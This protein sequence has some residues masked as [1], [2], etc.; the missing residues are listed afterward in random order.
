MPILDNSGK[1]VN[2]VFGKIILM[3]DI[4]ENIPNSF[5]KMWSLMHFAARTGNKSALK[6]FMKTESLDTESLEI[7]HT[8]NKTPREILQNFHPKILAELESE[9]E[10][11]DELEY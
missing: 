10:S 8:T 3:K 9:S 7:Y 5:I 1:D 4:P 2:D 6:Q 11:E